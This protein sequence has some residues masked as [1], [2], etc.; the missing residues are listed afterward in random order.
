MPKGAPNSPSLP[1]DLERTIFEIAALSRPVAIPELM[2]VAWRVKTWV[3]PLLYRSL[4]VCEKD[5]R[6]LVSGF[7]ACD[8][9]RFMHLLRTKSFIGDSVRNLML[10]IPTGNAS[11]YN[12][13]IFST[14][15]QL[16]IELAGRDSSDM[17][18]ITKVLSACCRVEKLY[19]TSPSIEYPILDAL[20]SIPVIPLRYLHCDFKVLQCLMSNPCPL[21]IFKQPHFRQLTHLELFNGLDQ[22]LGAGDDQ[23]PAHWASITA[24]PELTHLAFR[25]RKLLPICPYLLQTSKTLCAL[26][27]LQLSAPPTV[28]LL[29][30]L[31]ADPRFVILR[32]KGDGDDCWSYDWRQGVLTGRDYWARADE[33][34]AKRISGEISL[35]A[36]TLKEESP[37]VIPTPTPE[38]QYRV[39][40]TL[41]RTMWNAIFLGMSS[42]MALKAYRGLENQ[43]SLEL[44]IELIV[45]FGWITAGLSCLDD[46]QP[47]NILSFSTHKRAVAAKFV[48]NTAKLS[49]FC[50]MNYILFNIIQSATHEYSD[51]WFLA[52]ILSIVAPILG[53]PAVHKL[54]CPDSPL[55]PPFLRQI[56]AMAA[57]FNLGITIIL[58]HQYRN[59]HTVGAAICVL[60][61]FHVSTIGSIVTAVIISIGVQLSKEI[62]ADD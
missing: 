49:T 33:F 25:T 36:Y 44:A 10:D 62:R 61:W 40:T 41:A 35:R 2:R 38:P 13:S 3:E 1:L 7:P 57:V 29:D 60:L 55:Q 8:V 23:E 15:R 4:V 19:I 48:I 14:L 51:P 34:I 59:S 37:F 24:L 42:R 11:A 21:H 28:I 18:L 16:I 6:Y 27:I 53:A 20:S 50:I 31:T 32:L 22:L 5:R 45:L 54:F 46:D 26:V 12:P 58:L 47:D 17:Q 43:T 52:C 9:S 56:R 30:V 39:E